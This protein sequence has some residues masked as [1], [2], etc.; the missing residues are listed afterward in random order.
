MP[1]LQFPRKVLITLLLFLIVNSINAEVPNIINYQG[2]LTDALGNPVT[3]G[4][5]NITFK[6]WNDSVGQVSFPVWTGASQIVEVTDGLFNCQVQQYPG[7]F[8]IPPQFFKSVNLIGYYGPLFENGF[9]ICRI[10]PEA[11]AGDNAFDLR[12][13]LFDGIQVKDN[14]GDVL[15]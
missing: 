12:Q 11:V 8:Q 5:F 3:D 14:P 7:L 9:G 10:V 13:A 2:R 1:R 6:I 4:Q 15:I